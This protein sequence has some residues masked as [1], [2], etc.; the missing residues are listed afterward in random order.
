M[1]QRGFSSSILKRADDSRSD[2]QDGSCVAPGIANRRGC[3]TRN[4]VSF[5]VDL[6]LLDFFQVKRLERPQPILSATYHFCRQLSV[7]E[8]DSLSNSDFAA[9]AN[10]CL[11]L[12]GRYLSSKKNFNFRG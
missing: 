3:L 8:F 4:L 2:R 6:V 10:Q 5:R 9:R 7:S 1:F 12:A 11:P